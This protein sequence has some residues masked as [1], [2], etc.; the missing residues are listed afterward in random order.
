MAP[1][2]RSAVAGAAGSGSVVR[3]VAPAGP[4]DGGR[5]DAGAEIIASWGLTVELGEPVRAVDNRLPYLAGADALRAADLT[6]AW[7]DPKVA[8]VWAARAVTAASG[9]STSLTGRPCGRSGRNT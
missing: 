3:V 5:L 7:T 4:I 8:A 9:S 2:R 1:G 6:A